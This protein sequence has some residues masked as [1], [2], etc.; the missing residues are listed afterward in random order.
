MK[1]TIEKIYAKREISFHSYN[2]CKYNGIES[3]DHLKMY[4]NKY[5]HFRRLHKC[6]EKSNIELIRLR[7]TYY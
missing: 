2:A 5:G 1:V 3:I 4:Y 6:G 7:N